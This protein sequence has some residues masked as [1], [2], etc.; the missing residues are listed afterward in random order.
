MIM[1]F[2]TIS[3]LVVVALCSFMLAHTAL[4]ESNLMKVLK[5]PGGGGTRGLQ[6]FD[7]TIYREDERE[8][9]IMRGRERESTSERESTCRKR[10]AKG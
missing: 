6:C 7:I 10:P 4:G 8:R 9:E 5:G 1:K 2:S 3:T